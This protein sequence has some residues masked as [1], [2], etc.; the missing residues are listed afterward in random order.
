ME[1]LYIPADTVLMV[2]KNDVM[3]EVKVLDMKYYKNGWLIVGLHKDKIIE[4]Y[5]TD[6]IY[7]RE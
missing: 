5:P 4:I 7:I 1:R 3:L 6:K 2:C